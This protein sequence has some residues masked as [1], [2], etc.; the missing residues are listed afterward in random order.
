MGLG[1]GFLEARFASL[2]QPRQLTRLSDV[3]SS[4]PAPHH[5]LP[6]NLLVLLQQRVDLTRLLVPSTSTSGVANFRA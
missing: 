5:R 4:L 1:F 2:G 3:V 6:L